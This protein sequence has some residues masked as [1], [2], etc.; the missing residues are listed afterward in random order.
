MQLVVSLVF[1]VATGTDLPTAL[2]LTFTAHATTVTTYNTSDRT[3]GG[4]NLQDPS[5]TTITGTFA[6]DPSRMLLDFDAGNGYREYLSNDARDYF[7]L[8]GSGL[9]FSSSG[10]RIIGIENFGFAIQA[11]H[12]TLIMNPEDPDFRFGDLMLEFGSNDPSLYPFAGVP[13]SIDDFLPLSQWDY[14]NTPE[15]SGALGDLI[16]YSTDDQVS[17]QLTFQLDSITA[18]P[19]PSSSLLTGLGVLVLGAYRRLR[20][21]SV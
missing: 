13:T 5:T 14:R 20:C 4:V 1:L 11:L 12:G 19:K 6:Y 7:S 16:I 17:K 8:Q 9:E 3:F 21:I 2:I 18:V 15:T 10:L